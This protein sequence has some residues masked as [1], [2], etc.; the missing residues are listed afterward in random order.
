[1]SAR[2]LLLLAAGILA[3]ALLAAWVSAS[4][5]DTSLGVLTTDTTLPEARP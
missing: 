5:A 4:T 3:L 1:M 2:F